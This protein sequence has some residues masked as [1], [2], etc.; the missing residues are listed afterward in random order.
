MSKLRVYIN[1]SIDGGD[2]NY[3]L[4]GILPDSK[5]Q[6]VFEEFTLNCSVPI[7]G[8]KIKLESRSGDTSFNFSKIK[9]Y[10]HVCY[11]PETQGPGIV[12]LRKNTKC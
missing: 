7:V 9:V 8:S 4:C 5:S 3:M 10:G 2:E 1:T 6:K 12:L 11:Q